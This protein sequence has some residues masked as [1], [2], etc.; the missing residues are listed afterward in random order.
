MATHIIKDIDELRHLLAS[1]KHDFLLSSALPAD[2]ADVLFEG[3]MSGVPVVWNAC[4]R[5]MNDNVLQHAA[6][7]DPKQYIKIEVV[8]GAYCLEVGLHV[9]E[10]DQATLARTI[11]MIRKYKRLHVGCHRFGARSKMGAR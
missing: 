7:I 3:V 9:K 2:K 4:I 11:I 1:S 10:I 5:T 8:N 6:D